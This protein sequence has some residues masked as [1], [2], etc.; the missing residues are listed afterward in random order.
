[1]A[2]KK[3]K[4]KKSSKGKKRAGGKTTSAKKDFSKVD[5]TLAKSD[6]GSIQITFTIP[7]NLI[8]KYRLEATR[9]LAKDIEVAGFRKGK[10]PLDKVVDKIPQNTLIEKTLSKILPFIFSDSVKKHNL[11]PAIYPKFELIK[12]TDDED[13]QVRATTCELPD[14]DL[15]DYKKEIKGAAS[16][17]AI[18]TPDKQG[19]GDNQ[20]EEKKLS[21]S[22]KEQQVMNILL[23]KID[24]EIPKVLVED[25][26]NSRLSQLV[27]KLEKLG[28]TL[29]SY[30]AST[31]KDAKQL[32]E[33]YEKQSKDALKLDFILT[34]VA[35]KEGVD[36]ED[37][38]IDAAIKATQSDPKVSKKLDTPE[39]RR[40]IRSIL[41]RRAALSSLT[42]LI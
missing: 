16:A 25:D 32:R 10:A 19:K 6:D 4:S 17:K 11:K 37:D 31:K 18:W 3:K 40:V 41:T 7:H 29:E 14:I 42:S 38:Q 12:A 35:E 22:E 5:S 15:G 20:G 36:I 39:Q 28:L 21:Q 27:D 1:M 13:W 2:A 9:E 23:D 8:Q 30:L 34:K 33:T 24:F 26:V